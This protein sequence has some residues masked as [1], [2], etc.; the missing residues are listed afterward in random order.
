[1]NGMDQERAPWTCAS[2]GCLR[3]IEPGER[4]CE[5]CS[6]EWTLFQRETRESDPSLPNRRSVR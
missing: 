3:P 6:I 1:M 5:S 2:E 4:F